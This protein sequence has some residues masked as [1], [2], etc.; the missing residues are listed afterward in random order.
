MP[1]LTPTLYAR[2]QT[3]ETLV[4]GLVN[5]FRTMA[6]M[7]ARVDQIIQQA[8]EQQQEP[9]Q[10]QQTAQPRQRPAPMEVPPLAPPRPQ[11]RVIHS[12][13]QP[14]PVED[15]DDLGEDDAA[16]DELEQMQDEPQPKVK[17]VPD[18][19]MPKTKKFRI[20]D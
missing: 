4:D 2:I 18:I 13:P 15:S 19:P 12:N 7:L 11:P 1:E 16:I 17:R 9:P 3:L 6:Q 5:D 14:Q 8:Q 20:I 10:Q